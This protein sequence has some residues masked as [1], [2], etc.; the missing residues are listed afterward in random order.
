MRH[1]ASVRSEPGSNSPKEIYFRCS[2]W[3]QGFYPLGI[4]P[5]SIAYARYL[6][7]KDP[8]PLSIKRELSTKKSADPQDPFLDKHP[9]FGRFLI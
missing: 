2:I 8:L 5:I 1:A 7:F 9:A 3:S 6:V 4:D